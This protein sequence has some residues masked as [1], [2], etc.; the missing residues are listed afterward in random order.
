MKAAGLSHVQGL[1]TKNH[2]P[3]REEA[4]WEQIGGHLAEAV[5]K[6]RSEQLKLLN[7]LIK[8]RQKRSEADPNQSCARFVAELKTGETATVHIATGNMLNFRGIDVIVSSENNLMQM[9]RPFDGKTVSGF[10]REQGAQQT[11]RI[12]TVQRELDYAVDQR[13][14]FTPA[15]LPVPLGEI[16]ST[17]SGHPNSALRKF[18]GARL[19][20]ACVVS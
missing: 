8:A 9:A 18:L 5:Q 13:K 19:H 1:A 2:L 17:S 11:P 12:D 20:S 14:S 10:L 6:T 16:I 7:S 4:L 3:G 15:P